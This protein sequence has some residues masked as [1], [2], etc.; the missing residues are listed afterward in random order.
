MFSFDLLSLFIILFSPSDASSGLFLSL[1]LVGVALLVK[2]EVG[3][4]FHH[5]AIGIPPHCVD[6]IA[7]FLLYSRMP[8]F[9]IPSVS[10]Y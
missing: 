1:P 5:I 10:C 6:L 3:V 2:H 4:I 8:L 9:G 7:S